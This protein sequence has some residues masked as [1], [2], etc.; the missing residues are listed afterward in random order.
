V[1]RIAA[2]VVLA[3]CALGMTACSKQQ[4]PKVEIPFAS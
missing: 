3:A 1:K 4:Q 2:A